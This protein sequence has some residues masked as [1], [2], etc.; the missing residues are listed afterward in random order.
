MAKTTD[1]DGANL[2]SQDAMY[3]MVLSVL[4]CDDDSGGCDSARA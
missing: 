3:A 4:C 2:S 1:E